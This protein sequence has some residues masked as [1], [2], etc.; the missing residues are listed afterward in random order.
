[1]SAENTSS[2]EDR[3]VVVFAPGLWPLRLDLDALSWLLSGRIARGLSGLDGI[4]AYA[5]PRA[6]VDPPSANRPIRVYRSLPPQHIVRADRRTFDFANLDGTLFGSIV[7]DS[8]R[9][10]DSFF[11]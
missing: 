9:F 3:L 5:T 8:G 2:T 6:R 10:H 7:D 1:M 11:T 4:V